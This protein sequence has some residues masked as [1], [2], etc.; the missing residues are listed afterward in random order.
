MTSALTTIGFLNVCSLRGKVREVADFLSS[1]GVDVFGLAETW[2]KPSI[3]EGELEVSHYNL[4]R[5]D[6]LH[7]HGGGVCVYCHESLSVRRRT[8]LESDAL[9]I[10][11]LDIGNSRTCIRIGCG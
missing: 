8:D 5:K 10:M 9:E 6:R 3:S 11:W 1:L 7:R 2:L 4:F